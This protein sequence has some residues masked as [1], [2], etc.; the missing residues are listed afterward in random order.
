MG[1]TDKA[2]GRLKKAAGDLT[3]SDSLR[4]EGRDEER[5]GEAKEELARDKSQAEQEQPHREAQ[6]R[7]AAQT[8]TSSPSAPA[9]NEYKAEQ[10]EQK[11]EELEGARA[12]RL[13]RPARLVVKYAGRSAAVARRA[14]CEK[15]LR[16]G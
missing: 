14:G 8:P 4:R 6:C 2:T 11:V 5:K 3:G 13:P 10:R 15:T 16:P 12:E 9:R 7:G 1:T